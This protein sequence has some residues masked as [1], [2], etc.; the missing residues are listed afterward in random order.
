MGEQEEDKENFLGKDV[1]ILR[2][3]P[4]AIFFTPLLVI[5]IIFW[6]IQA[7]LPTLNPW[8]GGIWVIIFFS[9]FAVSSL[10]FPSTRFL[11][12]ILGT[13]VSIF[14]TYLVND[15]S[16]QLKQMMLQKGIAAA[17][18]GAKIMSETHDNIIENNIYSEEELF[19]DSLIAYVPVFRE[20][21]V[22]RHLF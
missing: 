5:S 22:L 1:V 11:I 19:N 12:V 9:N 4:K 6:I 20:R 2:S 18:T 15:R 8:L 21:P 13:I 3:Y 16:D 14:T 17:Q 10:D 7:F